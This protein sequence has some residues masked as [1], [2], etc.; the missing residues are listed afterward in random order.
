MTPNDFARYFKQTTPWMSEKNSPD[1]FKAGNPD[2]EITKVAVSWKASWEALKTAWENGCNFFISHESIF[3]GGG[4]GSEFDPPR[5]HELEKEKADW[6]L[7]KGICIYR[8]HDTIDY[9]PEIGIR[10]QWVKVL[11][12]TD[13]EVLKVSWPHVLS[14]IPTMRLADLAAGIMENIKPLGQNGVMVMGDPDRM[15]TLVATG[16]GAATS[17]LEMGKLEPDCYITT[18]DFFYTVRDGEFIKESGG[19]MIM[20]NHGVSEEWGVKAYCEHLQKVFG[21]VDFMFIPHRCIYRVQV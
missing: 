21:D 2:I 1:G 8:C 5:Y 6:I 4:T 7:D 16:T 20:V 15:I 17:P 14:R 3:V 12:F 18:E 11:D 19:S 13:F 9:I 10:D